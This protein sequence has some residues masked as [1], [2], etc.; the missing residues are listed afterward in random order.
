VPTQQLNEINA[1]ANYFSIEPKSAAQFN[2]S[3]N[4]TDP[5][6]KASDYRDFPTPLSMTN[7]L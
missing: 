3:T 4:M 5:L 6:Y 7:G 2:A 1:F